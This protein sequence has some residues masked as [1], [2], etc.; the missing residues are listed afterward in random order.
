MKPEDVRVMSQFMGGGFGSGLRPQFEVV[1]AVLGALALKRSVRVVLMR[2]QMYGLGYRPAMIQRIELGA[3]AE[4]T[5]EAL[6]HEDVTL[7]SPY[8][9]FFRTE[10][11]TSS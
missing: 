9:V 8:V 1:L 7:T 2:P 11:S 3:S 6:T 4:G 10:T 5:L